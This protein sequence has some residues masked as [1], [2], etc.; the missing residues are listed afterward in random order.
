LYYLCSD[1]KH[2]VEADDREIV[3]IEL[4]YNSEIDCFQRMLYSVTQLS[5]FT[6]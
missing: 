1:K 2:L 6:L 4:Q 3:I 5:E